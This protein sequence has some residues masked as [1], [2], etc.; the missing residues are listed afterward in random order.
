MCL[1]HGGP[2]RA[3]TS[4]HNAALDRQQYDLD[5][6]SVMKLPINLT[7]GGYFA[8]KQPVFGIVSHESVQKFD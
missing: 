4:T 1:S 6:S 5:Q 8:V 3:A 7:D 2:S